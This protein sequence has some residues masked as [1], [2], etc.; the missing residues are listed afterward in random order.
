MTLAWYSLYIL[1]PLV[2]VAILFTFLRLLRGPSLADRVV[3]LDVLTSFGIG[4]VAIYAIAT[5]QPAFMDV[6]IVMALLVFLST[7][8]FAYFIERSV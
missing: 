3:A 5:E 1:L 8:G 4:V 7:V 6:A 2:T